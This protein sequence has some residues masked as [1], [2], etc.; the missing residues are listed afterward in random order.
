MPCQLEADM[1]ISVQDSRWNDVG[2]A[3]TRVQQSKGSATSARP[4][5]G[6]PGSPSVCTGRRHQ[7]CPVCRARALH[8][9]L[10]EALNKWQQA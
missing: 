7:G 4:L 6:L 3:E 8:L 1:T 9:W 10:P 2:Q 5:E